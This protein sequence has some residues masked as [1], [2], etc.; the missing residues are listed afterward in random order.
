MGWFSD[1]WSRYFGPKEIDGTNDADVI[2]DNRR[3]NIINALNGDDTITV[4][5]GDDYISGGYG[6]DT[7]HILGNFE[8]Y[9]LERLPQTSDGI[10]PDA[11]WFLRS[12]IYGD[13]ELSSIEFIVDEN[14]NTYQTHPYGT[15]FIEGDDNPNIIFDNPFDDRI[16]TH[17]GDDII[18]LS[19]IG[20]DYVNGGDGTD[21]V[22]IPGALS[23]Y[24]AYG[25]GRLVLHNT[26]YGR[27][28][29]SN[30]EILIDGNGNTYDIAITAED[31]YY[32]QGDF[33][34][35]TLQDREGNDFIT[36]FDGNDTMTLTTGN[37]TAIGGNGTDTLYV[38][39]SLSDYEII[40]GQQGNHELQLIS[41]EYG[42]KLIYD[43]E[44]IAGVEDTEL[45]EVA[46][47]FA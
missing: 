36:G 11:S 24:R 40:T 44:F 41:E 17:G 26:E 7:L 35:N 27:E 8:D 14:G 42:T 15:L 29:I 46:E 33:R 38:Q 22:I 2:N 25:Q 47:L 3:D 9:T 23:D 13:K 30:A 16:Y 43:T 4:T 37:D 39:G 31:A 6:E 45:V 1:F 18:N 5:Y 32:V 21:T 12:N 10:P 28:E 34:D 19:G 20:I